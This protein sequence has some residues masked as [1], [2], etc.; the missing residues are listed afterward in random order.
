MNEIERMANYVERSAGATK[1][2]GKE[3]VA[4]TQK[5]SEVPYRNTNGY[6]MLLKSV[7]VKKYM[8][9][10]D[11]EEQRVNKA[12]EELADDPLELERRM[13]SLDEVLKTLPPRVSEVIKLRY[14]LDNPDNNGRT[15]LEIGKMLPTPVCLER[16]RQITAKGI[17]A[18]RKSM[19]GHKLKYEIPRNSS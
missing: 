15:F 2:P 10:Y 9:L 16:A 7:F 1:T 18:M 4:L 3:I 13:N 12:I 14:G 19:G 11:P 17:R 8:L 5:T 6:I